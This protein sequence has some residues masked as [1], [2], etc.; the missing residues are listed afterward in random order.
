MLLTYAA[1]FVSLN[2]DLPANTLSGDPR[3]KLIV[4]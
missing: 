1:H 2:H 3:V 4:S